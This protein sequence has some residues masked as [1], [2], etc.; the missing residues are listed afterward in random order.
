MMQCN[1]LIFIKQ[2]YLKLQFRKSIVSCQTQ[3]TC[4]IISKLLE[5][6]MNKNDIDDSMTLVLLLI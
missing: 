1:L 2:N 4:E 3:G 5:M 6:V